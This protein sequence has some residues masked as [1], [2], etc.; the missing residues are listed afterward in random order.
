MRGPAADDI[1][2]PS[3]WQKPCRRDSAD[4]EI[5]LVGDTDEESL[6]VTEG[7]KLTARFFNPSHTKPLK[8]SES[9]TKSNHRGKRSLPITAILQTSITIGEATNLPYL[10]GIAGI[11]R[12]ISDAVQV[13]GAIP[14]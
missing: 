11:I 12:V 5:T 14:S 1:T 10:K 4:S 13:S 7:S 3:Q 8:Y 9:D 2:S 6:P